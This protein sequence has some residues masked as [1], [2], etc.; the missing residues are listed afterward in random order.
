MSLAESFRRILP[1]AL[2]ERLRD[3]SPPDEFG[4]DIGHVIGDWVA[5]QR[6]SPEYTTQAVEHLRGYLDQAAAVG[7]RHGMAAVWWL[8]LPADVVLIGVVIVLAT[9]S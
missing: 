4:P 5:R 7:R 3:V 1:G 6:P 9:R 2:P 8:W